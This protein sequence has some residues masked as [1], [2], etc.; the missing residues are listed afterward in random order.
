V[1]I[2]PR[3]RQRRSRPGDARPYG[4]HRDTQNRS[5][6]VVGKIADVAQDDRCPEFDREHGQ[7]GIDVD[8][9]GSHISRVG[10]VGPQGSV[11]DSLVIG[12]VGN[13]C[14]NTRH[15]PTPT[16]SQFVDAGIGGDAKQPRTERA[17]PVEPAEGPDRGDESILSDVEGVGLV[18]EHPAAQRVHPV[19]VRRDQ[20]LESVAVSPASRIENL[21]FAL[22]G[23]VE[24]VVDAPE[25]NPGPPRS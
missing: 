15:G 2:G 7:S 12:D 10:M 18:P 25:A 5:D 3:D 22:A 16:A 4:S 8:A 23:P 6:L 21:S 20:G 14:G 17:P 19:V 13:V 11:A 24:V 9:G 1:R